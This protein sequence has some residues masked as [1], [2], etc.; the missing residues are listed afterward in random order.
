MAAPVHGK[1]LI[2]DHPVKRGKLE[3][4]VLPKQF[5]V[6]GVL[7]RRFVGC[8]CLKYTEAVL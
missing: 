2:F 6:G 3:D 5:P 1:T 7:G 8:S 4:R